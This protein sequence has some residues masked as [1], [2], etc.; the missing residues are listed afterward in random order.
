MQRFCNSRGR[1]R[2]GRQSGGAGSGYPGARL[3][4]GPGSCAV[5]EIRRPRQGRRSLR[6]EWWPPRGAVGRDGGRGGSLRPC[7]GDQ[8]GAPRARQGLQLTVRHFMDVGKRLSSMELG[9]HP[10]QPLSARSPSAQSSPRPPVGGRTHNTSPCPLSGAGGG[11]SPTETDDTG[12]EASQGSA[13]RLHELA[14]AN[15][16]FLAAHR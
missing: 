2:S 5:H 7:N 6:R 14:A 4:S 12:R 3:L 15:T 8:Q 9:S 10:L 11:P 1:R 13:E 16:E